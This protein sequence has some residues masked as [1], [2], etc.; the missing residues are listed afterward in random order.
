MSRSVAREVAMKLI[1]S[2]LVGGDD[3]PEAII[4]KS[5]VSEEMSGTDIEFARKLVDGVTASAEEL[6]RVI[7]EH[8]IG[9]SLD[10]ISRVDLS[11]LRIAL[12]EILHMDDVP[13]GA[14]INEA[15]KLAKQYG[16]DHSYSFIN[17]ILG[18]LAKK[19]K[20]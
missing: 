18:S 11:I 7:S 2:R 1:Y 13:V 20:D 9:W 19:K 5:E 3:T 17:G 10:R 8:A 4:E 6:D 12:Y 14:T 15:V 16:G